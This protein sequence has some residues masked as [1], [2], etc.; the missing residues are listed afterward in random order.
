VEEER[1]NR[2]KLH[3]EKFSDLCS[4]PDIVW[5]IRLWRVRRTYLVASVGEK[6]ILKGFC[7]TNLKEEN[8]ILDL[9]V[10]I[11]INL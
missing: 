8:H 11:K 2:R 4:S 1:E 6:R 9:E 3:N 7:W 10:N 5:A